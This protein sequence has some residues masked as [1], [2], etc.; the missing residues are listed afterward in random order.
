M[1]SISYQKKLAEYD[2]KASF[3]RVKMD[4]VEHEKA[5]FVLSVLD[6]TQ[7]DQA[8]QIAKNKIEEKEEANAG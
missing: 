4:Q 1:N 8:I 3:H 6:A 7:K 5:L 2:E